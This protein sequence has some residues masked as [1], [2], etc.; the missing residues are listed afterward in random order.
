M[1]PQEPAIFLHLR[2]RLPSTS[3]LTVEL[4]CFEACLE[5]I[6]RQCPIS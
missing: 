2:L 4:P 1:A 3:Q 5:L 6:R